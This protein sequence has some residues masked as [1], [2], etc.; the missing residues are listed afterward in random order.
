MKTK[1]SLSTKLLLL[2]L[3]IFN[4]QLLTLNSFSQNV[5]INTTGNMP[6][7]KALLDL[8]A[9]P[10]NDKGL[11]IPRLSTTNRDAIAAPIPESL[12]IYNTTT[13]CFEAWNGDAW[14]AFGCICQ[15]PDPFTATTAT[16]ITAT[17]FDAN[18]TASAGA[19][20]Y[21]LDVNTNISFTGTAILNNY[22]VGNVTSFTVSDL[23][24]SCGT[25]YYYRLRASNDCGSG[26]SSNIIEI[27]TYECF[28][29]G[30]GTGTTIVDVYNS[31]TG[32]TWMDRNLGASRQATS[33]TDYL[34]YGALFQW[35]RGA[36]GHECISWTS[37]T[38]SDGAEQ[39]NETSTLATS[40]TPGH[41]YFITN[42]NSP[43]DWRN[44]QNDSL[45]QGVDGINNPCPSGYR[46]PT[47]AEWNAERTS[48][49]SNNAAG[50]F[51]SPL[52]LPVAGNRSNS[53]GSL[54]LVGS[55]GNY[56]SS[57]VGGTY[58][59]ILVFNSSTAYMFS[60]NRAYGNSVR[61]I[62]D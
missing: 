50:A 8:D 10:G 24:L 33:S 31:T 21:Y 7:D 25:S 43:Y 2:T 57:T 61:C 34:A 52:K 16:N 48:W 30:C 55:D 46:L 14:V 6:N 39:A 40:N 44:P 41:S 11:L 32:K 29:P 4:F 23:S 12:L 38:T 37:A 22:D 49:S 62:K 27:T 59:R 19:S 47:E 36:D 35:G 1:I 28:T 13:Q 5:G 54:G 15:L 17:S 26:V 51:A 53:N 56:W 18:W 42:S 9:S 60:N 45:W 20:T 3:L 58:S